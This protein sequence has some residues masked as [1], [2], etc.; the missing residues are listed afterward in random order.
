MNKD[1]KTLLREKSSLIFISPI[2]AT[3]YLAPY[4]AFCFGLREKVATCGT[5]PPSLLENTSDN[6]FVAKEVFHEV[7]SRSTSRVDYST[8]GH[9]TSIF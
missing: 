5:P 4:L 7:K 1:F 9:P 6:T 8:Q 3:E 2:Q